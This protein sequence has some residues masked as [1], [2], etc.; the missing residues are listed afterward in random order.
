MNAESI[1]FY[2]C[3]SIDEY[4][5]CD[6]LVIVIRGLK[7]TSSK[8]LF[9]GISFAINASDTNDKITKHWESSQRAMEPTSSARMILFVLLSLLVTKCHSQHAAD[10]MSGNHGIGFR[11]P[12]GVNMEVRL[13]FY[14]LS[15]SLMFH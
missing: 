9:L 5:E 13:L 6:M 3:I 10:W 14:A 4:F 7:L 12:G 11:I 8:I 15:L 1:D 2:T